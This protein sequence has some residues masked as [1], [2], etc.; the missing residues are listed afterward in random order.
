MSEVKVLLMWI[1][2]CLVTCLCACSKELKC[3]EHLPASNRTTIV[4]DWE[5]LHFGAFV[6]FND[7][8]FI[9]KEISKNT[10]PAVFNPQ[11]V[12]FD[13]M[14]KTFREA[15]IRYAVLTTRHTSGFC[16]WDSKVTGFDVGASPYRKDVVRLFVKACRKYG[17]RPCLYYCL[18]GGKDW[19]PADWNPVIRKEL[20][21]K[22]PAKIIRTQL[23]ELAGNYGDISEFWMDMYCWCDTSLSEQEIYSLIRSRNPGTFVHFNQQVQDGTTI[24]YFPTDMLNGEER[25][26]PVT[27]H[28]PNRMVS[29][30]KYYLPFEYEITS[31]HCDSR[32]LGHGLMQGSVW[33]TYSDSHFYPVDSLYKYIRQ[34]NARGGSNILLSTAPDKS[35]SYR[36]AD[37]DSLIRLGKLIWEKKRQ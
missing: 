6:H 25:L 36:Q 29:G 17:I 4:A 28:N 7:N 35:G 3:R 8:T 23:E 20:R 15:G 31:Q 11:V 18:W 37:R 14:M 32:S 9:E 22:T 16:L 2:V 30:K 19:N 12:D 24:R 26:P 34:S 27:G 13:G 21:D 33:F 10:D 1:L 5:D